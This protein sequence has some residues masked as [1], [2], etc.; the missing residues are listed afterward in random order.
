MATDGD[1]KTPQTGLVMDST[2]PRIVVVC[3]ACGSGKS[4]ATRALLR[5][6]FEQ[7]ILKWIRIYSHTAAANHE[8]DWAPEGCVHPISLDAVS[9]YHKKLLK[10]REAGGGKPLPQNAI[11]WD[12]SLGALPNPYDPRLTS[13]F[14]THRHSGTWLFYLS[15]T[16]T[17]IPTTFRSLCDC[18]F[19]FASRFYKERRHLFH[20]CGS[21]FE[22]EKEFLKLFDR[23][24]EGD[25]FCMIYR[26]R[27]DTIED[28]YGSWKAGEMKDFRL[29][30]PV[31]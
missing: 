12:D 15:Q 13:L 6:M 29:E 22:K 4:Y 24:T 8:Y 1:E 25:H 3:G 17:G 21:W 2:R 31:V 26:N 18:G 9:K 23:C 14:A 16:A 28:T 30:F 10:A 20:F 19:I 7:G 11:L 5:S 27:Q